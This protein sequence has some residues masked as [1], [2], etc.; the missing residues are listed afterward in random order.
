MTSLLLLQNAEFVALPVEL[1]ALKE[2]FK[3]PCPS[4]VCWFKG[5]FLLCHSRAHS[6]ETAIHAATPAPAISPF[7]IGGITR[8]QFQMNEKTF[9]TIDLKRSYPSLRAHAVEFQFILEVQMGAVLDAP[10]VPACAVLPVTPAPSC[11]RQ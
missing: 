8:M 2:I 1:G 11:S 6:L 4:S 3:F 7:A 10:P 9:F 5:I